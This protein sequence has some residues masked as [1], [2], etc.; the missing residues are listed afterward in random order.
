LAC[1]RA[2]G[3]I[4]YGEDGRVRGPGLG[5]DQDAALAVQAGRLGDL[6]IWD[7]ANPHKGGVAG[8]GPAIGQSN[9]GDPAVLSRKSLD[10][11]RQLERDPPGLMV[12]GKERR[13]QRAGDPGQDTLLALD[14]HRLGSQGPGRGRRL[15]PDIAAADH[16]QPLAGAKGSLQGLCVG[17]CS[18]GHDPGQVSARQGQGAGPC[19]GGQD[20]DIIAEGPSVRQADGPGRPV[21]PD[22]RQAQIQAAAVVPVPF[23]GFQGQAGGVRLTLEPGLAEGRALIGNQ[24]LVAD[25]GDGARMTILAQ[26][27]RRRAARMAGSGNHHPRCKIGQ[28]P[29]SP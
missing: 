10:P 18:Q 27:G 12:A 3:D 26:E 14:D 7:G 9:A 5:V 29:P 19:A 1:S 15:Q 28:V 21:Q 11:G 20:Q 25:Q 23:G 17:G 16:G 8:Q 2:L 24:E 6:V 4:A 22:H 13:Q